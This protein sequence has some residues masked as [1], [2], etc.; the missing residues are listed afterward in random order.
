M[1][2]TENGCGEAIVIFIAELADFGLIWFGGAK[3][4]TTTISSLYL[5]EKS[6]I[7]SHFETFAR[8]ADGYLV[9]IL[10]TSYTA[11]VGSNEELPPTPVSTPLEMGH[12][13]EHDCKYEASY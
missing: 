12:Y 7:S 6:S 1:E 2:T 11:P 4:H 10:M 8:R 5:Y 3:R 9:I 13:Q